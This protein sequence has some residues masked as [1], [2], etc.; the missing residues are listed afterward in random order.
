MRID[1]YYDLIC[2][3]CYIGYYRLRRAL[4]ARPDLETQLVWHPFQLNPSLAWRGT[5]QDAYLRARYGSLARARRI[6][7]GISEIARRDGLPIDLNAIRVT[8][9]STNAHVLAL[10]H[11]EATGN[12]ESAVEML[13][14]AHCAE[15]LNLG[16]HRALIEVGRRL[17]HSE[18]N[19]IRLFESGEYRSAIRTRDASARR[20]GIEAVPSL[21]I[22]DQFTISG[23]QEP[24]ALLPLFDAAAIAGW[25]GSGTYA[26]VSERASTTDQEITVPAQ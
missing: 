11:A 6:V 22:D 21:V 17:G 16:S 10:Y 3:W 9:N 7:D 5:N 18:R 25:Y 20:L 8:P 4:G 13:M 2:P 26:S 14:R 23:A 19:L 1:I 24:N 12:I 15:G